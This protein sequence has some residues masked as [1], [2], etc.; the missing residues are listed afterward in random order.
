VTLPV[1][2]TKTV[3]KNEQVLNESL[4]SYKIDPVEEL[5]ASKQNKQKSK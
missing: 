4:I 1:L 3:K 5:L 2:C